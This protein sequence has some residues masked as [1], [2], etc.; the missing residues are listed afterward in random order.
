MPDFLSKLTSMDRAWAEWLGYV[1]EEEGFS[2]IIQAWDFRPG[3]NFVLEMQKA[4]SEA[5]RNVMVL[6]PDYLKSQFTSSEWAAAFAH[7]PKGLERKL[8]PVIVRLAV[9]PDY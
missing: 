4:A 2:V 1:L 7:D 3:S 8:V 6:S 9:R 5:D